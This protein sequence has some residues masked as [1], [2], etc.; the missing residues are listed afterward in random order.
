[1]F[2]CLRSYHLNHLTYLE[3]D[4][5]VWKTISS[6]INTLG[7][8]ARVLSPAISGY[9]PAVGSIVTMAGGLAPRLTQ[10]FDRNIKRIEKGKPSKY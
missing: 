5:I 8:Y 6:G 4:I 10:S 7:N 9:N 2:L 1:M 3:K